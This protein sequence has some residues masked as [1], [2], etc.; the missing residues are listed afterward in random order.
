MQQINNKRV[1]ISFHPIKMRLRFFILCWV[2]QL[3]KE[4]YSFSRQDLERLSPY[5]TRHIKHFGDYVID[6]QKIP[7]PIEETIPL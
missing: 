1:S 3:K 4:G 5:V 2:W 6:L 7:R